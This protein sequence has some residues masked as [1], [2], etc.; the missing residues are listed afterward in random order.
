MRVNTYF[1]VLVSGERWEGGGRRMGGW[2]RV[3]G[4]EGSRGCEGWRGGRVG[5][6][7]TPWI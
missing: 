4:G 5:K 3:E 2:G 6:G 7:H 1:R